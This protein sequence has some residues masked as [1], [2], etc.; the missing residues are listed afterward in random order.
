MNNKVLIGVVVVFA[1]AL[2]FETAYLLG[3]RQQ[4][5]T[6]KDNLAV[7]QRIVAPQRHYPA[8]KYFDDTQNWDPFIEME[9]MQQRMH[10]LFEDSFSRGLMDKNV[11]RSPAYFDPDISIN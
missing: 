11:F 9:K 10:N 5:N 8:H 6:Y 3:S 7:N 2:I 1:A 4:Q